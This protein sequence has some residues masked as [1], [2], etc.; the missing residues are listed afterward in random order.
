MPDSVM[1]SQPSSDYQLRI[2]AI[3]RLRAKRALKLSVG[4]YVLLVIVLTVIWYVTGAGYFWPGWVALFGAA[5]LVY[6][7]YNVY[8]NGVSEEA[9]QREIRRQQQ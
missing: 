5:G 2:Q 1:P 6:Q 4:M 8:A 3:G 9:I 7:G